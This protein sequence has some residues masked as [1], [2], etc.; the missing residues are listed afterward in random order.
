MNVESAKL[1][2]R[3][4][5]PP[6]GG[7]AEGV[8]LDGTNAFAVA[9]ISP[10]GFVS[11]GK[12]GA[13]LGSGGTNFGCGGSCCFIGGAAIGG[14]ATGGLNPGGGTAGKG[15]RGA[16]GIATGGGSEGT[17]EFE[18]TDSPLLLP[19]EETVLSSSPPD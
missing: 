9:R 8:K 6:A 13:L 16:G 7:A 2:E 5:L 17:K 18:E 14:T 3:G 19:K 12:L 15:A 10:T 1:L 4:T 11:T